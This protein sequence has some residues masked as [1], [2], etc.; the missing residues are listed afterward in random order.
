MSALINIRQGNITYNTRKS[1]KTWTYWNTDL[2][3]ETML[4]ERGFLPLVL[5]YNHMKD[6][7]RIEFEKIFE[8]FFGKG[9]FL[10]LDQVESINTLLH[11]YGYP[12]VTLNNNGEYF[13]PVSKGRSSPDKNSWQ[14]N[15]E[16][17]LAEFESIRKSAD[18]PLNNN[19][20]FV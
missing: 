8:V 7:H 1:V 5:E 6:K 2:K 19:R 13:Q 17:R 10:T 18:N 20:L 3:D 11:Y 14:M 4:M 12:E 16:A 15:A 9:T